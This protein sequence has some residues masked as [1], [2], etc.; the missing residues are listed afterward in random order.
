MK[1]VFYVNNLAPSFLYTKNTINNQIYLTLSPSSSTNKASQFLFVNI[2]FFFLTK[3]FSWLFLV[4]FYCFWFSFLLRFHCVK[5]VR[6]QSFSSP[7]FPTFGLNTEWYE[8]SLCIQSEYGKIQTRKT[9]KTD[10]FYTV[11]NIIFVSV[12]FL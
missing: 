12:I 1:S 3:V 11:F 9:L 8:V 7:Y 5:S 4:E 6:I 10:T 2:I